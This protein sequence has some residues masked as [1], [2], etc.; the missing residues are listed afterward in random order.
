MSS[1]AITTISSPV[2]RLR[3]ALIGTTFS[4]VW[5]SAFIAGKIGLTATGPLTLLSLRF[6]LAGLIL[7]IMGKCLGYRTSKIL[8][9]RQAFLAALAAGLLANAVYLGLTYTGMQTMPAGLTAILVSTTPLLTSSLAATWLKEAFG[10]RGATGLAAGFIGVLWI[11]GGRATSAPADTDAVILILI[12]TIALA[13]STLLNKSVVAHLDPWNIALIQ[14]PT[15]GLALLPIAWWREGLMVNLNA[16]LFGS[17]FYQAT[18]VSIGTTLML[19]WLVR[20]GGTARASSFHLLNPVFGTMLAIGVLGEE[21]PAT[22][23]FGMI[24]IVAG[25]ALVLRPGR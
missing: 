22:D 16:A 10:W 24:P 15:S 5:S 18:V 17:L 13:G 9:N 23:L 2:S 11:M 3:I 20:H 25:L 19:L 8:L 4:F 1:N 14:L 7:A 12:G 21:I 6:L